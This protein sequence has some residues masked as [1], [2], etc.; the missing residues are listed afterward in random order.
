MKRIVITAAL[1]CLFSFLCPVIAD[2]AFPAGRKWIMRRCNIVEPPMVES[3]YTSYILG[4]SII[5]G[6]SY[7]KM[8]PGYNSGYN[9]L[10]KEG[11][12]WYAYERELERDTLLF[13][14]S[15]SVGDTAWVN[16]TAPSQCGIIDEVGELQGRKFWVMGGAYSGTWL[17]GLGFINRYPFENSSVSNGFS[18]DLICCVEANGD[19]LYVNR[20]L[21][22]MFDDSGVGNVSAENI[23]VNQY[24]GEF[25]VTLPCSD[26]WSATLYNSVVAVVA[27]RSGDGS[28]I[29]LPATSKGTHILV[30][31]V[32]GR[33][34][35]KKVFIK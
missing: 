2:D 10:R 17:E 22:Y 9:L 12:K 28:E 13:D 7:S 34:V 24:G 14:E 21:F 27:R 16:P 6:R 4:S 15:W 30:L 1:S 31:N 29:V 5:D 18:F 35:K 33:V 23:V 26:A 11:T 32:G 3:L 19:T 8:R 25:V 20:E